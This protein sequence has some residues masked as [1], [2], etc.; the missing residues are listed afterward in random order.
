MLTYRSSVNLGQNVLSM[1]FLTTYTVWKIDSSNSDGPGDPIRAQNIGD[2]RP[3]CSFQGHI[4]AWHSH[5]PNQLS[6]AALS[7]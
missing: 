3:S 4:L 5:V 7:V 6:G 1:L 2:T